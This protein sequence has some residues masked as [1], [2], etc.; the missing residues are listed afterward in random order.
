MTVSNFLQYFSGTLQERC[1][2]FPADTNLDILLK[3][4]IIAVLLDFLYEKTHFLGWTFDQ[5]EESLDIEIT[6]YFHIENLVD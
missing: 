2:K 3:I 5:V 6:H 1:D 4:L